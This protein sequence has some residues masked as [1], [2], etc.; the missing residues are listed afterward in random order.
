MRGR[1]TIDQVAADPELQRQLAEIPRRSGGVRPHPSMAAFLVRAMRGILDQDDV[2]AGVP[3]V[4]LQSQ[5]RSAYLVRLRR[6]AITVLRPHFNDEQIGRFF[7]RC[8]STV[9]YLRNHP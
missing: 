1:Q 3:T 4:A 7:G 9:T 2:L 8:R 6:R 5:D